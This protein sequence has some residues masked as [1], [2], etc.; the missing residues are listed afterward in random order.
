MVICACESAMKSHPE[1]SKYHKTE[2]SCLVQCVI[3]QVLNLVFYPSN[4]HMQMKLN[5]LCT[6]VNESLT[7]YMLIQYTWYMCELDIF[8]YSKHVQ[9]FLN[10]KTCIENLL[11]TM[12]NI[13]GSLFW[14]AFETK[15]GCVPL[16]N[17]IL[18][19]IKNYCK[20]CTAQKK[21]EKR[22]NCSW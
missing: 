16:F 3:N 17:H 21:S 9:T 10:S 19:E 14:E 5:A 12:H 13:L 20:K 2:F 6:Y 22:E 18:R 7:W 11:I 1:I 4:I 15:N 8:T